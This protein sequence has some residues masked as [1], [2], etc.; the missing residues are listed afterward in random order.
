MATATKTLVLFSTIDGD[1]NARQ[2]AEQLVQE[3][4]AAC[5]NI[6]PNL[7][8]V[9]KWKGQV[10]A[11]SEFLLVLK[12]TEERV[13][14]L[15]ERLV[16]LHPYELPEAIAFTVQHGHGPYLDWIAEGTMP[17]AKG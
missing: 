16:Q 6:I 1:D 11:A 12:T 3:N 17:S 4:L 7:L 13:D 14:A 5:V 10:E 2:L 8:S 9:Y 15:I